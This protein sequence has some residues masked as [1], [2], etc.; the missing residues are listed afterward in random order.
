MTRLR[1]PYIIVLLT[2]CAGSQVQAVYVTPDVVDAGKKWL[3]ARGGLKKAAMD[4]EKEGNHYLRSHAQYDVLFG[5]LKDY[6]EEKGI[7]LVDYIEFEL[8]RRGSKGEKLNNFLV[9][10]ASE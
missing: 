1:I 8:D 2:V 5:A 10:D 3:D 4:F 7:D 9:K 6:A